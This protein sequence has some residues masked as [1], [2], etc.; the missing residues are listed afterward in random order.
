MGPL[1]ND[2]VKNHLS[3]GD[4]NGRRLHAV[5]SVADATGFSGAESGSAEAVPAPQESL[6]QAASPDRPKPVL[7][8]AAQRRQA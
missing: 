8:A 6:R 7:V 1:N 2:D 5:P 3:V 4:R